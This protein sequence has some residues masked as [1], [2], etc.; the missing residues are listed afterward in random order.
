MI[1]R[2]YQEVAISDALNALDTHKN[3][4]VVAPTGAGKT[5]MLSALIGKRHQE[6]KRILVLQHRDE[7]V[8]Q[9]RE[10]FLKVNPNISTSIV[11][12]TIKKW[13]GDTIFSMVQTLSRENNLRHRPKFDMVVVDESH[14][15][16]A[17]TYMRIIEAVKEDNEH[18]EIVGFT[19][20][21]NRGDGKGLRSVFTNCSHQIEL[22]TLIREGFLVPPKAYVVDVGVTE[23][24]EGVTRRG[25]DFDMDEVAQIMNKRVIN[26]R[27]VNEWQDR[28]GDRKTVV[29]C[30][31]I[32]HAQD[33]LDMFIEHDINAE[34]VIGDTP[35]PER[36]QILHDL[37]FGDVQV[38]VNV[39]VLTE[40]FDAPPVSCVVL[41][42]PCSF[43]STMV[44]MIG[45]GLRILD[46][47]I[48]PDQIKKDCI[49]LD[50]GSS[51]LTH[52]AL[53]E[54]ANLDGKPKDSNGE[55]P[56]KQCPECGFINPLNVRMC[57]ECG[58]EFQ[59]QDT[60]ELV[61]F[62][63]TEYD[64]MELSPFLWMDI[65]GN[66]SCLMAMGFN[67]FGV[68]GTVGDTS[69]GLVKAQNGRKVRSVAIGGKVQAM[70]AADDF[71]REIEDSSAA[72]KSKR[73]L[74]ERATDKQRDALRRGGVQVSAMDFSWTKYKAAC[75]LNYLWNKEQIDAAVE[76]IAE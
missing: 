6:G 48:Y 16:A 19:A 4:I 60:E 75:W 44:Q 35:K 27:V 55:A 25:N 56:E 41:T 62:T 9:N 43:K 59:S 34:M 45:R 52:G 33:L 65:F 26:E 42:R 68:V 30:S 73:W 31:T 58:Y 64:L 67:G 47:E 38:V 22:A 50:F 8:A 1:L 70:S 21:P 40:G 15:A 17:D 11:N 24:L 5:I 39:A 46:P 37:E 72:N 18:A 23:A 69:I 28:A 29:F 20:T 14:H 3:T 76:R 63:L 51:I 54:A 7:L 2:P 10:K 13:D 71:M 12:G 61:D 57:V 53:D 66:G 36:E 32:N 74:N 49:V